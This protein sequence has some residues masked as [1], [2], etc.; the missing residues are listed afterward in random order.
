ML[1]TGCERI[2]SI[3]FAGIKAFLEPGNSLRTGPVGKGLRNNHPAGTPLQRVVSN[4]RC[5]VE[6]GF[7]ITGFEAPTAFLLGTFCPNAGKAIR[8]ELESHADR[9]PL[10]AE[11]VFTLGIGFA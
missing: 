6:G 7:D 4:P 11:G 10:R 1:L 3:Y 8:L 5:G 9:V 2:T